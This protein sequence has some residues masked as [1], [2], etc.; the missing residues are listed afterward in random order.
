[1]PARTLTVFHVL[2]EPS[3]RQRGLTIYQ[4]APM[5]ARSKNASQFVLTLPC[6]WGQKIYL[7][8][9]WPNFTQHVL[10]CQLR[11]IVSQHVLTKP[12]P[13]QRRHKISICVK[14]T[15]SMPSGTD[16]ASQHVLNK[17]SH[18][19]EDKI[20]LNM[21]KANPFHASGDRKW[22]SACVYLFKKYINSCWP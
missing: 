7:C 3:Q 5:P 18:A 2:T 12:T 22:S 16:K 17:S 4:S 14:Q 9:C 19:S 8:F 11:T 21:Y 10:T 15:T 6:Q 13:C 1:M 20:Y